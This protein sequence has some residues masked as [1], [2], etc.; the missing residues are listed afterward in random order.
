MNVNEE[1][2][3][4]VE[5]R[6]DRPRASLELGCKARHAA[7]ESLAVRPHASLARGEV[8][9]RR[10]LRL[11][12]CGKEAAVRCPERCVPRAHVPLRRARVEE[13][14]PTTWDHQIELAG[15]HVVSDV[16]GLH[17]SRGKQGA[18]DSQASGIRRAPKVVLE[19]AHRG[20]LE[21]QSTWHSRGVSAAGYKED[22][23]DQPLAGRSE[24]S[25][26]DIWRRV[27]RRRSRLA[28]EPQLK[29]RS[30]RAAR[31][32][33]RGGGESERR[34]ARWIVCEHPRHLV[35]AR[36]ADRCATAAAVARAAV[37]SQTA[38]VASKV[39]ATA[40]AHRRIA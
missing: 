11:E 19:V 37:A 2:E 8:G 7:V 34:L 12:A 40:L 24:L 21:A 33:A 30:T 15:G 39:A 4:G 9:G 38:T 36:V 32:D 25:G 18:I 17:E 23:H 20:A 27:S 22:L 35:E 6:V 13:A 28:C 1:R 16:G 10:R 31:V 3:R 29:A 5:Q 14:H 26:T